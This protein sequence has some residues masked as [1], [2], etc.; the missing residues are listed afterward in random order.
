[1]NA[2]NYNWTE[3][4]NRASDKPGEIHSL[5]KDSR[6]VSAASGW[7]YSR[8]CN[9]P[10]YG[11][12]WTMMSENLDSEQRKRLWEFRLHTE[13]ILYNRLAFF[14]T[15]E[16]VLLAVVGIL[17]NKRDSPKSVLIIIIAL[18]VV[19]TLIW[20]YLQHNMKQIF[21]VVDKRILYSGNFLEHKK[22]V[23]RIRSIRRM[24][25]KLGIKTETPALTLLTYVL[26]VLV[27]LLWIFLLIFILLLP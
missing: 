13:T 19:I 18:G 15:F 10:S 8:K 27:T 25:S 5:K 21:D 17:Y 4:I 7:A 14:L 3:P 1:M 16:T 24:E 11:K 23:D 6:S 2:A 20:L 22:T 9:L 26:P 12:E